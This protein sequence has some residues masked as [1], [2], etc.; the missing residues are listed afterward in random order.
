VHI[1]DVYD[2]EVEINFELILRN[3]ENNVENN[4][5]TI[6]SIYYIAM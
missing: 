3:N 1:N 2:D 6:E 4:N 5:F